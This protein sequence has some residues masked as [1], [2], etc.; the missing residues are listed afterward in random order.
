MKLLQFYNTYAIIIISL[1]KESGPSGEHR[2]PGAIMNKTMEHNPLHTKALTR[3]DLVDGSREDREIVVIYTDSGH[4][5]F[6][7]IVS[8]INDED[9][10]EMIDID[11]GEDPLFGDHIIDSYSLTALGV[12]PGQNGWHE[13]AYVLDAADCD[14]TKPNVTGYDSADNTAIAEELE[15]FARDLR[16]LSRLPQTG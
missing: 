1:S 6:G 11:L 13:N 3:E 15:A 8:G 9:G 14:L 4:F 12:A 2:Q 16:E 5:T 10:D 7:R